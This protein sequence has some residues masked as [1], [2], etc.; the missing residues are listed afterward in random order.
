MCGLWV[1]SRLQDTT[2][3]RGQTKMNKQ[4]KIAAVEY[5]SERKEA[6]LLLKG[7]ASALKKQDKAQSQK[8]EDWGFVGNMTHVNQKLEEILK[9][10][11]PNK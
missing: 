5:D 11:V 3:T 8:I 1:S 7:I 10:L 9:F 6:D 4:N 2:R